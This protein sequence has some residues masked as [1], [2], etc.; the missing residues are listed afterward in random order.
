[1]SNLPNSCPSCSISLVVTRL[2]CPSCSVQLEGEFALPL[3]L[4]LP[5][6]DLAFVLE[7]VRAS[8]SLKEMAKLRG[9]SYPTI[10]NRLNDIIERLHPEP[11][12]PEQRRR[13]ILDAIAKGD[14]S[15]TE[16]TKLLKEIG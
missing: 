16:A 14:L 10:R 15:V 11:S 12:E 2:T 7:F 8:G 1:M 6:D 4:R 13:Q 9:Q 5:A 3:L